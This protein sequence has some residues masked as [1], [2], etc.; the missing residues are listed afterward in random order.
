M[1]RRET[2]S[3]AGKESDS[4]EEIANYLKRQQLHLNHEAQR[5]GLAKGSFI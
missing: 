4:Q 2:C 1:L 5:I 3:E